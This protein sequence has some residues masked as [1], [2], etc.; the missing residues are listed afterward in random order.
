MKKDGDRVKKYRVIVTRDITESCVV[1]VEAPDDDTAT[2][3]AVE[4]A[5]K[6]EVDEDWEVDV[7]S[8]GSSPAYV[9]DCSEVEE[10]KD[11]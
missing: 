7:D 1:L 9:T 10:G 5:H 11:S 2:E 6:G 8:C 4:K 3:L